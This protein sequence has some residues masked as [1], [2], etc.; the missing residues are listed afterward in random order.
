MV[1]I[2]VAFG[3]CHPAMIQLRRT[4]TAKGLFK[5]SAST[6]ARPQTV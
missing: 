5:R 3:G 2:Y 6:V 1:M 4:A